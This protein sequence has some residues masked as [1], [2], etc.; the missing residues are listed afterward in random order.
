MDDG[1]Q[2][3]SGLHLQRGGRA[4]APQFCD[5]EIPQPVHPYHWQDG[6]V[7][8]L[9]RSAFPERCLANPDEVIVTPHQ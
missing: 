1:I 7:P 8:N 3:R 4:G 2:I 5:F 6:F 9:A